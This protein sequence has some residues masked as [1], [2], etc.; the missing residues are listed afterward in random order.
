MW[1]A[2]MLEYQRD[3]LITMQG[4]YL[5]SHLFNA[6]SFGTVMIAPT[7]GTIS[8]AGGLVEGLKKTPADVAFIVPSIVQELSQ[9]P[10]LLDYC[11][12]H[13]DA[14]I[15]CGG[16]LPEF[17]GNI[18]AS[19]IKLF[20]QFGASE[21]GLT[22]Q[23]FST[24]DR[25]PVDWKY[26]QFHPDIG[27]QLRELTDGIYELYAVRDHRIEGQQPTFT[28]FPDAQEYASRDLFVRHPTKPSLWSWRARADDIIVFLNGEKTNPISMEQHIVSQNH[29]VAAALVVGA[30]RFQAAL[31]IEPVKIPDEKVLSPAERAAFI[32]QI[33][34]TIEEANKDAPAHARIV[35]SHVLLTHPQK[36]MLRAGKGTVQRSGTLR[37]YADDIESL[38]ADADTMYADVEGSD[39]Q[40]VDRLDDLAV[41]QFIEKSILSISKWPSLDPTENIFTLGMDSLQAL[42][43]VREFRRG[44]AIPTVALTTVY[45]NPSVTTLTN[46]ILRL[47][48]HQQDSKASQ[49]QERH[50]TL[51][52]FFKEYQEKIDRLPIP[53]TEVQETHK[54]VVILTGSTGALGSH[55]L[56]TLLLAQSI[57]HIYCLNRATNSLA[58]QQKR[59]QSYGLEMQLN[60]SR[61]TFVT[62]DLSQEHLGLQQD[63]FHQLIGTAT[64]IIHNAWPVNFNLPLPAFR[65]Q[66]DS[67]VNLISF[68]AK[69]TISPRLSF[70][71]SISSVMSYGSSSQKIPEEL[72]SAESAPG[73]NGYSESKFLSER[74]LDHAAQKLS[75]DTGIARVGQIAG[76]V[77]HAGVWNKAEWF[78]SLVISSLHVGAIPDSLGP[79]MGNIDWVPIDDLAEILVD[80]VVQSP[81]SHRQASPNN[82]A[83]PKRAQV[84]HPLNPHPT[85]WQAIK[86]TVA[87]ELSSIAQSQNKEPL[88]T[89]T[90]TSW[91]QRI[92]KDMETT[93]SSHNNKKNNTTL[94]DS[95]LETLLQK[96][97][98]VKLL[99]FYENVL[100]NQ[101]R[102][103][104]SWDM[105]E[106]IERSAK[107]RELEGLREEWVRKWVREWFAEMS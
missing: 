69:S 97:P 33:W 18:V 30:Q 96:N 36:P 77:R 83:Q 73:P 7:S 75:I 94:A 80:L 102:S 91:L 6:I 38:Y 32:E 2:D 16:D 15:Y 98:A 53:S 89:I 56:H 86:S 90:L 88:Q 92:R 55:I 19:K 49:E 51:S 100:G 22:A 71:S 26:A 28:V 24:H 85:T 3:L 23:I 64:H 84:F 87:F 67:L 76:P 65:T 78:P 58:L 9:N 48:R 62:A 29:K 50:Q 57:T 74:L 14:I 107:V 27:I 47:S 46:A 34:P 52:S 37:M 99:A 5:V 41:S 60:A 25:G 66:L 68:T 72:I 31:L 42:L 21:L 93:A 39:V 82:T 4:A 12:K 43:L 44:L 13:L 20:N 35:K 79:T 101:E 17:I 70:I 103:S 61:V 45:T 11:S 105:R 59:N 54:N 81:M 106:T 40:T 1:V 95:D 104:R 8:T 10:E 63:V